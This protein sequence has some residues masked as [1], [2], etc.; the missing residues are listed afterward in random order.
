[1][2]GSALVGLAVLIAVGSPCLTVLAQVQPESP[3][4]S[5]PEPTGPEPSRFTC[6]SSNGE[7][8]V[9]YR[10]E[11]QPNQSFAWAK[12]DALGGGW[13]SQR[14][15][16]EISRRL[17][18]YRPDGLQ[19]MRTGKENGYDVVCATTQQNPSCRIIFTVPPGN[20]P[21]ATR[22]R[23][24]QNIST[25]DSGQQTQAVNTYGERGSDLNL[26]GLDLSRLG[27]ILGT[28]APP[29]SPQALNLR[30]FLDPADGGTGSG[31]A[32]DSSRRPRLNPENFR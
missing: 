11:S 32:P 17:E 23:V 6:E 13:T 7:Y 14:R 3:G 22:D 12:P 5:T 31:L 8:M 10:P 28:L 9:M 30:P 4:R 16:A 18:A 24:F 20:D 15:C 2:R 26:P 1:M 21:L 27:S 25:A 19:E 29:R